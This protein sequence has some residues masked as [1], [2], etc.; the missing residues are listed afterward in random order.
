MGMSEKM[1]G[2]RRGLL[3]DQIMDRRPRIQYEGAFY[4][5]YSRGNRRERIY[6]AETDFRTFEEFLLEAMRW[7]G[8]LLYAWCLMPNHFHLVVQTPDGDLS[9]FMRQ[10]M[11]R[12]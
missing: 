11:T 6:C 3:A 2:A 12:Y 9:G 7:S 1:Q 5:V 8:V 4:H 10:L